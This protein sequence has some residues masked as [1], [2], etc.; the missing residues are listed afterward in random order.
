MGV[1]VSWSLE[2][3]VGVFHKCVL[4]NLVGVRHCRTY[5][6]MHCKMYFKNQLWSLNKLFNRLEICKKTLT[7]QQNNWA[8]N[9][10]ENLPQQVYEGCILTWK[11]NAKFSPWESSLEL[12]VFLHIFFLLDVYFP[13]LLEN[14]IEQFLS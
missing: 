9:T 8:R 13:P 11:L 2:F 12:H 7:S 10:D 5:C 6:K 3:G 4:I 1:R 14:R